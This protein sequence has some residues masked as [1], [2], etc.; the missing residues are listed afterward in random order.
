MDTND[1]M[2]STGRNR[3]VER[4][5]A[6]QA[7]PLM[8]APQT[9]T[10]Q[11]GRRHDAVVPPVR[12]MMPEG[13]Q[14]YGW[15]QGYAPQQNSYG[16]WQQPVQDQ[17]WQQPYQG[18][19]QGYQGSNQNWGW[20]GNDYAPQGYQPPV[21]PQ[22][23]GGDN[24]YGGRPPFGVKDLLKLLAAAV[25]IVVAVS[26]LISAGGQVSENFALRDAVTAY[27]DRYCEGVYV[28]GIHLGGMT[29]EEAQQ[30]VQANAQHRA[31]AWNVRLEIENGGQRQLVGTIDSK[32]L[33]LNVDVT[34]AL[35]EAWAMGHTGDDLSARKQQMDALLEDN[36]HASSAEPSG[37]STALDDYL[38]A[39]AKDAYLPAAD[40]K[41]TNFTPSATKPFTI[42]DETYG[43]MLDIEPIKAQIS[44]M[45]ADMQSGVIVLQPTI[46][47]P[48]VTRADLERQLTLRGRAYTVI[49]SMSTENRDKNIIRACELMNG[50]VIPPGSTFSFNGVVGKRTAKNGFYTAI[51][52]AYGQEREGYGGGVC[53]VS[54]TIYIAAVRAGME[55]VKREQHSDKVNYTSYGLDATVNYDG[56]VIDFVFRNNTSSNIYVIAKVQRDPKVDRSHD[57]VI[58]DIYGEA[59]PEGVTYDL[60]AETV[61]IIPPPVE[62]EY[63]TDTTGEYALYLDE[64]VEKRAASD[65]YVI[66][67]YRVTYV[68]GAESERHFMARDTYKPK[69]QQMWV[70]TSERPL[71]LIPN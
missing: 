6:G 59:L 38:K 25:V 46:I 35:E 44:D 57:I 67:S 26:L 64:M 13:Q 29:R 71:D 42:Q 63:V 9:M 32:M 66:E 1:Q 8:S 45:I 18:N 56:K 14:P 48:D 12:G 37:N 16:T 50:T 43:R 4:Y 22:G 49:S 31:D 52:Y 70:G 58:I 28:D 39:L 5:E 11:R 51:E 61:E 34:S 15:Q 54:S 30:A 17:N 47:T 68:N 65:G 10:G 53:Q 24:S 27:N 60:V 62:I 69:N 33:G 55:I 36:Y 21:K 41:L 7:E 40:A 20:N 23:K 19:Q 3:R 2:S